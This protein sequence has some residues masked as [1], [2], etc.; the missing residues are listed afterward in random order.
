M[1]THERRRPEGF[2]ARGTGAR[3]GVIAVAV[4]AVLAVPVPAAAQFEVYR[5]RDRGGRGIPASQFA[6]FV[7]AGDLIVYPYYEYYRDKDAEY[8]PN[9]LG[10]TG[11]EDY[12]G[13]YRAHEGLIFVGY[14]ISDRVHVELEIAVITARQE[15]APDDPGDFPGVLEESGL[16]DVEAQLRHRWREETQSGPGI[17]GYFETVFP[18]QKSKKLI[19][20]TS[21]EF[22]Y[23]VGMIRSRSWGTTVL[24]AAIGWAEGSPEL[25]EYAVEYIRG[26]SDR[27]RVY[28]AVEGSE[29]EV[30]LIT[31]AQIFLT[32]D[33][34]LKL[35]NAFGLT[36]K[37]A[38]WAPEVGLMFTF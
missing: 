27:L 14:G 19:G 31:E 33:V 7:E 11:E 2:P 1:K 12:F 25:G 32:R 38:G 23:G 9:E 15:K 8:Q 35:N 22:Q 17:Y 4:L 24:R 3:V 5:D 16:G 26:V 37:A 34:K 18:F 29:D 30:E 21:W 36:K 13:A 20:T 6:T 10:Y 28:G